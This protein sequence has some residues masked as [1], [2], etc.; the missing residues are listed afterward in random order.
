MNLFSMIFSNLR[1]KMIVLFSRFH[2]KVL[3]STGGRFMHTLQGLDMLL[4][5]TVGR[6]TGRLRDNPL[7]YLESDGKFYCVASFG[8]HVNHPEWFLNLVANPNVHL[9]IR[10]Q[11]YTATAHVTSGS[12]REKAWRMLTEYHPGFVSYQKRTARKI[13]VVSFDLVADIS[14]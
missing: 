13:P 9:L 12:E 4:L 5:S 7:L 3:R 11:R 2:G 14:I 10:G 1:F 6:Q 8:G